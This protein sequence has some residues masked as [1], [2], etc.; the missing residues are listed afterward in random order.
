MQ[1]NW[2]PTLIALA[3]IIFLVS[4]VT[5]IL[6]QASISQQCTSSSSAQCSSGNLFSF[7]IAPGYQSGYGVI[8]IIFSL[9][10][11]FAAYKMLKFGQQAKNKWSAITILLT[12]IVFYID[13][14]FI[15]VGVIFNSGS[16]SVV[17][18]SAILLALIMAFVGGIIG[19]TSKESQQIKRQGRR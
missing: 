8:G 5:L 1:T 3:A 17:I 15:L 11:L 19:A 4:N 6:Q 16:S 14:Q 2:S 12:I 9:V 13:A 10:F 7:G 18:S